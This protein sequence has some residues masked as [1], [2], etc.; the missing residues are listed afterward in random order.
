MKSGSAR[1]FEHQ[2]PGGQYSNLLGE[3]TP[4]LS[5]FPPSLPSSL[6][7]CL[8]IITC[9]EFTVVLGHPLAVISPVGP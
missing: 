9:V 7:E 6:A 1:V 4:F 2:V 3:S 8:V 5:S